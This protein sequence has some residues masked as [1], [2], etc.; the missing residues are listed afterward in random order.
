MPEPDESPL[1]ADSSG[2][3]EA[4][5]RPKASSTAVLIRE[6]DRMRTGVD[7]AILTVSTGTLSLS[8]RGKFALD[9]QVKI[10][11]RNVVQRFKTETRGLVKKIDPCDDGSATLDIE[12]LTRLSALDVSLVKMG[13]AS[14]Q[15]GSRSKWV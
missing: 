5:R 3:P 14:P 15:S 7:A 11:L 12:L 9:E 4:S 8:T 1:P 6:A 10:R 13:I 2:P